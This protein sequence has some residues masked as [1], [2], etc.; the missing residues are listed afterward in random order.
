MKNMKKILFT[1]A[2]IFTFSCSA[3]EY[4]LNTDFKSIPSGAYLKDTNNELQ[5][6]IGTW[7][8]TYNNQEIVLDI[9]KND[10]RL[11]KF[12]NYSFYRDVILLRYT[13][14]DINGMTLQSTMNRNIINANIESSYALPDNRVALL[15]SGGDCSVGSGRIYLEYIDSVHFKWNYSPEDLIFMEGECPQGSDLKVYLPKAKDLVF[16]KQ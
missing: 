16:T 3:Q 12:L 6:F 2:I 11:I 4:P 7:K 14:K 13:I 15:Y 10:K 8:T 1:T 9:Q 5:R